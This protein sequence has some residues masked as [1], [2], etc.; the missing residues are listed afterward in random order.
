MS[1][2]ALIIALGLLVDN[3][4]VV[5][6]S[7][8]VRMSTGIKPIEAAVKSADELRVPLLT[9]SLTTAAAFLPIY[10][11]ESSTGEY[12][13]PLFKVVSIALICSWLLSLTLIPMLWVFFLKVKHVPQEE[14]QD[15][16]LYAWYRKIL[17]FSLATVH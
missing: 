11:V 12:T 9:S 1:L 16:R 14:R 4:I 17:L 2:A 3:A 5:S 10:L 15:F 13:A 6:E 7:I 8:M